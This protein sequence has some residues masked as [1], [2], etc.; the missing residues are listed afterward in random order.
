VVRLTQ[1]EYE[2]ETVYFDDPVRMACLLRVMNAK[3][4]HVVDL[5]AARG[6]DAS[7]DAGSRADNRSVI[8]A[9][10]T[11]LDIPVQV[12]GGLRSL[13]DVAATL[14]AGASRVIIGTAAVRDPGLV[15]EAL[16]RFGPSRIIVGLDAL[17]GEVRTQG[18]LEGSGMDVVDLALDMEARGVRRFVYTDIARDGTLAGPNLDAYRA[19]GERLTKAR[20][21]ASGGVGSYKDLIA[22]QT[23]E[24]YRV[25]SVIVGKALYEGRFA[26]QQFWCWNTKE[27]VDLDRF[28]TA[29]LRAER[30][31]E[32]V[33]PAR[34]SP[35]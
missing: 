3:V 30:D 13:E 27:V 5:D 33:L 15:D 18:W 22:L 17:N 21:T 32:P 35:R 9:I 26:C 1:G 25:D 14:D 7:L 23:L 4:L 12:G 10:T 6:A 19:L 28:S 16:G 20:I 11:K 2:R 8:R 34:V 31:A 29:R 24:P